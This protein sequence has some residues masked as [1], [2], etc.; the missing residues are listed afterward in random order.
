MLS[1][2]AGPGIVHGGSLPNPAALLSLFTTMA[3]STSRIVVDAGG[4]TFHT[5]RD[6]LLM[7]GAGYFTALF[8]PTGAAL[9]GIANNSDDE[10]E[11]SSEAAAGPSAKRSRTDPTEIFI[12]RNPD[13]F[14]IVLDFMRSGG[15]LPAKVRK[16]IDRLEDL[17]TEAEFFI[18]DALKAAC[19]DAKGELKKALSKVIGDEPKAKCDYVILRPL[20]DGDSDIANLASIDVPKGKVLYLVSAVLAGRLQVKRYKEMEGDAEDDGA[21]RVRGC[22]IEGDNDTTGDFRLQAICDGKSVC[23]AHCGMNHIHTQGQNASL[24][25]D[26]RQPLGLC[27]SG[28]EH[29]P[30]VHLVSSGFA[31]WNIVYW[32][33]DAE[34]IPGLKS[35]DADARGRNMARLQA[36][37]AGGDENDETLT[38]LF[39]MQLL[40]R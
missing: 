11:S 12:D 1:T 3:A 6:T 40:G 16:D 39:A 26:F 2:G 14:S 24:H 22:Y 28:G 34:A 37:N 31:D 15:K 5:T 20:G 21:P 19:D 9:G 10:A 7:S 32:V 38:S 30:K 27:L 8:G 17:T 25:V 33:G 18:Y 13:L 4:R 29:E 36:A 23:I 35:P